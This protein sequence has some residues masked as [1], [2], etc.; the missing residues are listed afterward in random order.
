TGDFTGDGAADILATSETTSNPVALLRNQAPAPPRVQAAPQVNDGTGPQRSRVTSLT[1]TF[2]A[3]VSFAGPVEAAF[4]LTR[5]GG[6]NVGGF[7]ATASVVNGVTVVVLSGFTGA[8][9]QFGSLADGFYTLR[10]L[11]NQVSVGGVPLDGDGNGVGG[12]DYVLA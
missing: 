4:Q 6:G 9:T 7:T 12:D 3:Q 10:V 8:E 11:A 2:T 1:V 5:T